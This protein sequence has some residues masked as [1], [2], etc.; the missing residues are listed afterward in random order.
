MPLS[1]EMQDAL[2]AGTGFF[3]TLIKIQATAAHGGDIIR[4]ALHTKDYTFESELYKAFPFVTSSFQMKA[5]LEPDNATMTH[6]LEGAF[7]RL[8]LVGGKWGGAK[9]I[10]SV[11]DAFNPAWGIARRHTG[12]LG[13]V[14]TGG[15]GAE[16]EFRG[17]IQLLSQEIGWKTSGLCRYQLGD[18][19]CGIDVANFTL[20]GEVTAVTNNQKFEVLLSGATRM[21]GLSGSYYGGLN[22]DVLVNNRID[23]TIDFTWTSSYPIAGLGSDYYT[24]R[25]EGKVKPQYTENYTFSVEHDDGVKL[26]VNSLVTPIIDQWGTSGDHSSSP[27][28]LTA[29]T[30]YDI[31]LEFV[32]QTL[33]SKVKL[34]W[35]STSQGLQIIPSTRLFSLPITSVA[36]DYWRKG[37]AVW[38]SG[39][40]AGLTMEVWQNVAD[41]VTLF[42][43]M[44]GDIQVG[45][46]LN[47]IA[48]DDKTLRT[49]WNKFNNAVNFGGEDSIPRREDVYHI[50]D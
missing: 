47:L 26:W 17:L 43:P 48:G 40:N 45:D 11:V 24:V 34:R 6:I 9:I 49:C 38:L 10:V 21:P 29:N 4:L 1:T 19:L 28:A 41:E 50:P 23:P 5:G 31:K 14:T 33:A 13:E 3:I 2:A 22:F 32:Q 42:M 7:S 35:Q 25:W 37:R 39:H 15:Y 30:L 20:D 36:D 18:A 8:N 12:R 46:T 27:I 44:P 16:S